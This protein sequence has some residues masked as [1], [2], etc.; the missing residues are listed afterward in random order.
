MGRV[1]IKST[2]IE[3]SVSGAWDAREENIPKEGALDIRTQ[4]GR[5][6]GK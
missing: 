6:E 2:S 1:E 5:R 4:A 3:H